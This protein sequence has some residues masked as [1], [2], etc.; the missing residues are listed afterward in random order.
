MEKD[1]V[2]WNFSSGNRDPQRLFFDIL[3]R[4]FI[5]DLSRCRYKK[6]IEEVV[7]CDDNENPN[8]NF[9]DLLFIFIVQVYLKR[10]RELKFVV[11]SLGRISECCICS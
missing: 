4:S 7:L 6:A 5:C 2:A 9:M 11:Q 3:Q 10:Y 1:E 8:D